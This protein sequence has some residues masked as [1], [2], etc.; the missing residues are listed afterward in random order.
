MPEMNARG[1]D[2]EYGLFYETQPFSV[3]N[4]RLH[5]ENNKPFVVFKEVLHT[6]EVSN[7]GNIAI[8]TEYK[9]A[10]EGATLDGEYS[11]VDY[12]PNKANVGKSALK[13]LKAELPFHAWGVYYRDEVGNISTS[14][15]YRSV[16]TIIQLDDKDVKLQITN[17]YSIFGGW[18]ANWF[19]IVK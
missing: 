11:R 14:H 19:Y 3:K 4:V 15:A 16:I 10:N 5:F 8:K 17:R 6:I 13:E 9:L 12:Q 18:K 7:W 2:V 1:G